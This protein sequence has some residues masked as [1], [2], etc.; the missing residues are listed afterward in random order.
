MSILS[1]NSDTASQCY[2][3]QVPAVTPTTGHVLVCQFLH[4]WMSRCGL[5]ANREVKGSLSTRLHSQT[6]DFYVTE[7][8]R[9]ASAAASIGLLVCVTE[10]LWGFSELVRIT[11]KHWNSKVTQ[12]WT[13]TSFFCQVKIRVFVSGVWCK[14]GFFVRE[15]L[16]NL[17]TSSSSPK[18]H[19]NNRLAGTFKM[20]FIVIINI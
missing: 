4:T 1:L 7:G 2:L 10:W 6:L 9:F 15:A 5:C 12:S 17:W 14:I 3:Q 19:G 18:H 16:K 11:R 8:R 20:F 13:E